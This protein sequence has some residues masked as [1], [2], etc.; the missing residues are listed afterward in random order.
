MRMFGW[1]EDRECAIKFRKPIS[2][3]V[4]VGQWELTGAS[5]VIVH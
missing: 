5:N 3:N 2:D 4:V 1:K